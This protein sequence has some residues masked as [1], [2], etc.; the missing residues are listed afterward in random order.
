MRRTCSPRIAAGL[1]LGALALVAARPAS[2]QLNVQAYSIDNFQSGQ[3][4]GGDRSWSEMLGNWYFGMTFFGLH[5]GTRFW[6]DGDFNRSLLCDPDTGLSDCKDYKYVDSADAVMIGL[7]GGDSGKHWYGLMRKLAAD[8]KDCH[9]TAPDAPGNGQLFLGDMEAEFFHMSSCNS[10]NDNNMPNTWRFFEDPV[11][12]PGNGRR[13]HQAT[14]FHGMMGIGSGY[15]VD[16]LLFSMSAQ[17]ASIKDAW[18]DTMYHPEMANVKCPVAYAVGTSKNNCFTRIDHESY[19]NVYSD[20]SAINY[21][22]Y[23]YYDKCD[24]ASQG[25]FTPPE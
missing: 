19:H 9:I 13:L 10:M 3:C 5:S 16:Y 17:F 12:S 24:P 7:H 14:G 18:M 20:P 15:D 22:C 4:G 21:Y 25:P 6:V 11:D 1:A 8:G 2:A 23:Y